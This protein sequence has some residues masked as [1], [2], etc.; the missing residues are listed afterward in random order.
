V[1]VVDHCSSNVVVECDGLISQSSGLG[2]SI[3]TA[4]C[5]PIVILQSH[6]PWFGILHAGWRGC[7]RNIVGEALRI[8][9]QR[10]VTMPSLQIVIG[11]H[12]H[13]Y[14]YQVGQNIVS[15]FRHIPLAIINNAYLNMVAVVRE[16]CRQHGLADWQITTDE[17]CTHCDLKLASYRRNQTRLR[18]ISVVVAAKGR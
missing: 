18:N 3:T 5:L 12:I 2:L 11:P 17:R 10:R 7:Q 9:K 6:G 1:V 16:Q 13:P 15:I 14:C 8:F 4:D